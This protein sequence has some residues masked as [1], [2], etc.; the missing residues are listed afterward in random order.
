MI[1]KVKKE[2]NQLI[3]PDSI[4]SKYGDVEYFD[5]VATVS[6]ITLRPAKDGAK[7]KGGV[8]K[9]QFEAW[10]SDDFDAPMEEFKEYM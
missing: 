4:L 10:M 8:A 3:L 5:V 9:I 6:S 1:A 7:K 2:N